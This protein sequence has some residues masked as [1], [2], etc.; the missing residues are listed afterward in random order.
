[1]LHRP[2]SQAVSCGSA[3]DAAAAI[4]ALRLQ[5]LA[6]KN[7]KYSNCRATYRSK[8]QQAGCDQTSWFFCTKKATTVI[9]RFLL[10]LLGTLPTC[11]SLVVLTVAMCVA[12][13]FS[14]DPPW[15]IPSPVFQRAKRRRFS[16][17]DMWVT[18]ALTFEYD[19]SV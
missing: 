17:E 6:A 2:K 1:V 8:S 15:A 12:A 4:N 19:F 13:C 9:K 5:A 3:F 14:S 7:A 10:G 11:V 16:M 18:E